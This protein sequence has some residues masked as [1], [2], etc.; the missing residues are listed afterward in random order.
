MLAVGYTRVSTAEQV[1][2]GARHDAQ[3]FAITA[4]AQ[5]AGLT[6]ADVLTDEGSSG[7]IAPAKPPGM[8][9]AL[10]RLAFGEA[11]ALIVAEAEF[12]SVGLWPCPMSPGSDRSPSNGGCLVAGDRRRVARR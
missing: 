5:I 7:S 10:D 2:S 9:V 4:H 11:G 8:A 1:E 6:V 3:R 12:V